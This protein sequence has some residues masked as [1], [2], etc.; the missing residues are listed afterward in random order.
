MM[1]WEGDKGVMRVLPRGPSHE[2]MGA[3]GIPLP[4][5]KQLTCGAAILG[6]K[7]NIAKNVASSSFMEASLM[8]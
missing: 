5:P 1:P 6:R 3:P 7:I 4:Y 8:A 2:M